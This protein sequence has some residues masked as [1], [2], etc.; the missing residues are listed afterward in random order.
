MATIDERFWDF[1]EA[2]PDVYDELV[3]M[4]RQAKARGRQKFGIELCFGALRWNRFIRTTGD[5][6]FKLNDHFTSRYSRLIMKLEP[7]LAGLF[8][9]RILRAR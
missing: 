8:E 7:D 6:G 9:T 1:H 3:A 4:A 5:Q 2:N